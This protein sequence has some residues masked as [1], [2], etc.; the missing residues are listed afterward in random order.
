MAPPVPL[1][2][3][4]W[5]RIRNLDKEKQTLAAPL[6][7]QQRE[8][9]A[10]RWREKEGEERHDENEGEE[11]RGREGREAERTVKEWHL[12]SFLRPRQHR[13]QRCHA[14]PTNPAVPLTGRRGSFLKKTLSSTLDDEVTDRLDCSVSVNR[15]IGSSGGL[16][17]VS[18]RGLILCG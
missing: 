2:R 12:P 5:W 4:Y 8:G 6:S 13:R 10:G 1:P 3:L 14:S 15:M 18:E 17:Q 9:S 16:Q 7:K 11:D